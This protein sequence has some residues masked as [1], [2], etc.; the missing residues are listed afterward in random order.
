M[1]L[2]PAVAFFEVVLAIH[3]MAAVVAFGVTFTYPLMFSIA[4]KQDQK[5]LPVL[6]RI[7]YSIDRAIVNPGLLVV[8]VAG[9]YLASKLHQWSSF[10]VQ[11]GLGA[12]IVIG[13]LV[14]SVMIPAG[15][16]AAETAA[17]DLAASAGGGGEMSGEYRRL[18][19]R[20]TRVGSLLSLLVLVTIYFMATRT[21]A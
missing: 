19:K 1:P 21:G 11:W 14:G 13:A 12:A 5:S 20:L 8:V 9:I 6:H 3:I 16:R 2:A 4:A 17:R 10:Y 15:K 7:A 18:V